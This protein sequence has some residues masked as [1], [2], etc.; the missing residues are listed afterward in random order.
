MKKISKKGY[1]LVIG[2]GPLQVPAIK[3]AKERG[4]SVLSVDKNPHAVGF[5]YSDGYKAID[6]F[7]HGEIVEWCKQ[8]AAKGEPAGVLTM[9]TDC[10]Y[11]VAKVAAALDLPGIPVRA[12]E[13]SVNKDLFR[14]ELR[15]LGLPAPEY[16]VAENIQS[17]EESGKRLQFPVVIKPVD[18][19]GSRGV[20]K[21]YKQRE[22]KDAAAAGFSFSRCKKI[23]LE[24]FLD[25]AEYSL[26]ACMIDGKC[27]S[28]GFA[29]RVIEFEP[30]FVETGYSIPSAL[31]EEEQKEITTLME[32]TALGL[33]IHNGIV[34]GDIK[35]TNNGPVILEMAT[36]LSGN[37]MSS[38]GIPLSSGIDAVG[39]AVDLASGQK[40]LPPSKPNKEKGYA[41]RALQ[42]CNGVVKNIRGVEKARLIDGIVD[43]E[44]HIS[45]GD[46]KTAFTCSADSVGYVIAKGETRKAAEQTAQRAID[47]IH[48]DI[49]I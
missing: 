24:E 48:F 46:I 34:K 26:D 2:A 19:M 12:A 20:K 43:I 18:N 44:L 23:I 39:I 33:G 30:Y 22:I 6:I 10:S 32:R 9:A 47:N 14:N 40:V 28:L 5:Q 49:G 3:K 38:D 11:T 36:R 17:A 25:G 35:W 7:D 27:Y 15:R 8:T 37:R 45:P 41:Y 1:I 31:L 16:A 13:V 4:Y 29:D 42:P 21:I